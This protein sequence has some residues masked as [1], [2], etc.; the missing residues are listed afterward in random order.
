MDE[1]EEEDRCTPAAANAIESMT[2]SLL[3]AAPIQHRSC[4]AWRVSK[5]AA[6]VVL[7]LKDRKPVG[8]KK[9][10]DIPEEEPKRMR[11]PFGMRAD[12]QL[13][14]NRQYGPP[15]QGEASESAATSKPS[16]G[17][18]PGET[19]PFDEANPGADSEESEEDIDVQRQEGEKAMPAGRRLGILCP[20]IAV[21]SSGRCACCLDARLPGDVYKIEAGAKKFMVRLKPGAVERSVHAQC[22][23]SGAVAAIITQ[24]SAVAASARVLEDLAAQEGNDGERI[25]LLAAAD[26]LRRTLHARSTSS[27]GAAPSGS[28]APAGSGG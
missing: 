24:P 12:L 3:D 21:N 15:P 19:G 22:V 9:G 14:R 4:L 7:S 26:E 13:N 11:L 5:V 23:Y 25:R 27:G 6:T 18:R 8:E 28:A 17:G 1:D 20:A 10:D 2:C 16:H